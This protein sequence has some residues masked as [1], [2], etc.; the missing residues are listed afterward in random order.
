MDNYG[1]YRSG[2]D[3]NDPNSVLAVRVEH[4]L[5]G[6]PV[7]G[8]VLRW[9]SA[10]NRTYAIWHTLDI[11]TQP[12][13][14]M[15]S[16]IGA[17][18]PTNIYHDLLRNEREFRHL[19]DPDRERL[20]RSDPSLT[21][22]EPHIMHVDNHRSRIRNALC[23][24]LLTMALVE[25]GCQAV[26][27]GEYFDAHTPVGITG[28]QVT[29]DGDVT[30]TIAAG[31]PTSAILLRAE[32]PDAPKRTVAT[33][34][35]SQ[36][37]PAI[38]VDQG[39][40][41]SPGTRYY[42]IAVETGNGTWTNREEWA[43]FVQPRK[44]G[45]RY[46]VSLPVDL[47]SGSSLHGELGRQLGHGL[48]AGKIGGEGADHIKVMTA[49]GKWKHYHLIAGPDYR[50]WWDL[51]SQTLAKAIIMP[52]VAF[53][54]ERGDGVP[55]SMQHGIFC[56]RT[57]PGTSPVLFKAEAT[58]GTPF[59]ITT[60]RP[61]LHRNTEAEAKYSTPANQLGFAA[62]GSGGK[63]SDHR[64]K[65][66]GGDQIWVWRNNEWQGY[67]WLMNHVGPKWD[68]R[69]WDNK[70]RDFADFAL[71]PGVGYYYRRRVD[72]WGGEDFAWRPPSP[73]TGGR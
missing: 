10:T 20:E 54:I 40:A 67:Y 66:E 7:E 26:P 70:T 59:G 11:G 55:Q 72:R 22:L 56:G 34:K 3:P 49:E 65:D 47:G 64:K 68:G 62:L 61:L 52:G 8:V 19:P 23:I 37:S 12:L 36:E 38:W 31:E 17:S 15:D 30:I 63:T 35:V 16:G 43:V 25:S 39:V 48:H 53:W 32:G 6:V 42:S 50:A 46:L 58:E 13:A 2:T 28:T 71:E 73:T 29:G 5:H 14:E 27:L 18:T 33:L 4:V 41:E 24:C 1:E 45:E 57:L 60:S 44:A 9:P 21:F 69:W 51:E